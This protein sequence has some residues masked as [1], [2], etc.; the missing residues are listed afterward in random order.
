MKN[1]IFV[2]KDKQVKFTGENST[3]YQEKEAMKELEVGKIYEVDK[4]IEG[5]WFSFLKLK[6]IKGQFA[7]EMFEGIPSN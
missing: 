2:G 6:G 4:I 5:R 7:I 3:P 1:S